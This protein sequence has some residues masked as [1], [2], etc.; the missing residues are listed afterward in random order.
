MTVALWL[1][2]VLTLA[3]VAS[4]SFIM[5]AVMGSNSVI[6]ERERLEESENLDP[7]GLCVI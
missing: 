2:F 7:L 1:W 4:L 6:A 3:V 5:G